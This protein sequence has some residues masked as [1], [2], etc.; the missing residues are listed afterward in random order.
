MSFWG[1]LFNPQRQQHSPSQLPEG[2]PRCQRQGPFSGG[3]QLA[4]AE[5]GGRSK[6]CNSDTHRHPPS[7]SELGSWS[8]QAPEQGFSMGQK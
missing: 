2:R 6:A 1:T 4:C 5:Q 7:R 3:Q 8:P